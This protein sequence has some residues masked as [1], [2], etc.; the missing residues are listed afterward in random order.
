MQTLGI[1]S[2]IPIPVTF[3]A[4]VYLDFNPDCRVYQ[5]RAV[6]FVPSEILGILF[7][8]LNLPI[9]SAVCSSLPAKRSFIEAEKREVQFTA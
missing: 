6:A 9:P 4:D 3:N 7:Q 5:V 1:N 8:R 2:L